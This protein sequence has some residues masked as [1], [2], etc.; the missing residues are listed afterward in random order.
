MRITQIEEAGELH[1]VA[2]EALLARLRQRLLPELA[3]QIVHPRRSGN[4]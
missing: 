4:G 3:E 2:R 1:G